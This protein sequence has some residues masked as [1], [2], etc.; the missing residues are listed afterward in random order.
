MRLAEERDRLVRLVVFVK[1]HRRQRAYNARFG[2]DLAHVAGQLERFLEQWPRLGTSA[3]TLPVLARLPQQRRG[4]R[5]GAISGQRQCLGHVR[6]GGV[7]LTGHQ[8]KPWAR[9]C[10]R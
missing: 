8:H 1:G 4:A 3:R 9:K 5:A 6:L 2:L 10:A 7:A